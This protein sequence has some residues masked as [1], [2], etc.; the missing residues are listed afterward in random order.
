MSP[1]QTCST[2]MISR[3]VH[4]HTWTAHCVYTQKPLTRQIFRLQCNVTCHISKC[5]FLWHY[6]STFNYKRPGRSLIKSMSNWDKMEKTEN[7][8]V[9]LPLHQTIRMYASAFV[10]L[11]PAIM[12]NGA[13]TLSIWCMKSVIPGNKLYGILKYTVFFY[14]IVIL[15]VRNYHNMVKK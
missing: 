8:F 7:W 14:H 1:S 5:C 9:N 2:H 4:T 15:Y 10:W 11:P 13:N 3:S 6:I 12:I